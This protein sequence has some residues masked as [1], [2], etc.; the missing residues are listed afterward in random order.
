MN[1]WSLVRTPVNARPPG[2]PGGGGGGLPGS[3]WLTPAPGRPPQ[4]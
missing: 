1:V 3:A 4:V 2:L